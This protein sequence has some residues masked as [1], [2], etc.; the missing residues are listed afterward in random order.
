MPQPAQKLSLQEAFELARR[1]QSEGKLE[2]ARRLYEKLLSFQPGHPGALTLL[3]SIH[4][5]KG[6]DVQ[7]DA[8]V[9]RAVEIYGRMLQQAPD[10]HQIRAAL[11]NQLLAR[12]REP[13]ALD[14]IGPLE[15]QM[16]P[17]RSDPARF[18]ETR[19]RAVEAGRPPILLNTVP[20]SASETIWNR[21]AAGLDM[22]QSHLS[23]GLF[24]DCCLVPYRMRT[25]LDGGVIAKEHIPASAHNLRQLSQA[26]ID[27]MVLH[28]RDPRQATLSW[29]HF[30]RDDV[31]MRLMAPIWRKVVPPAAVL[32]QDL[33]A[34]ID[35]AIDVYLP[36][37]VR[38]MT[39]WDAVGRDDGQELDVTFLS[40]ERFRTD[41]EGYLGDVLDVHGIDR[42]SFD[43][44]A[45]G[46][47][48]HYRKGELDEWRQVFT[49][50]QARR[51]W[52]AIPRD[53]ARRFGWT[54]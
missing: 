13:E 28:V 16:N 43:A 10:N 31:S 35:W 47:D 33:A 9:N 50:Q 44:Q 36:R 39:D 53:L 18:A 12:D 48:V 40:F 49:R 23:I 51:A 29:V 19:R 14:A 7:A 11:V 54:A 46:D 26:G 52:D 5:Q 8:Y 6:D 24:P 2:D 20:K 38:F 3:G 21:L 32:A 17:V 45:G 15:L 42:A 1:V 4:Y 30:V 27:R 25:F 37:L 22:A 41:P 34:T